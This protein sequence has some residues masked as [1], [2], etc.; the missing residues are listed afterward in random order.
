M[1]ISATYA[2]LYGENMMLKLTSPTLVIANLEKNGLFAEQ[3]SISKTD[4]IK[5]VSR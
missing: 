3:T 1:R 2:A 4:E 5:K